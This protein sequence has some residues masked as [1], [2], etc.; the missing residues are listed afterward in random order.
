MWIL[1]LIVAAAL[2]VQP[3]TKNA[4]GKV[5]ARPT[6]APP[7]GGSF[8]ADLSS[9][10]LQIAVP[11]IGSYTNV[12]GGAA[13]QIQLNPGIWASIFGAGAAQPVPVTA[14]PAPADLGYLPQDQLPADVGVYYL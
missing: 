2:Y 10:K 3:G 8:F 6:T 12:G 1:L 11:N 4:P 9:G 7:P 14:V 13:T 5:V